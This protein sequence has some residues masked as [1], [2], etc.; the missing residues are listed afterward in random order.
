MKNMDLLN[1]DRIARSFPELKIIMAHL[2]TTFF[3][4]EASELIKVHPNLYA[5][6]A[7]SGSWMAIQPSELASWMCSC[8]AEVDVTFLG[9]KKLLLGSDAY[10]TR[11]DIMINAQKHY[12]MLLRRIGVPQ[13]VMDGIMGK[14]AEKW[15]F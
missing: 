1:L 12:E 4:K 3:R 9:F 5:D 11:P 7:G 2:G 14:T 10:F 6:L 8:V 13:D 15:L